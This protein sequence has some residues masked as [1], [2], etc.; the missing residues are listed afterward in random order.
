MRKYTVPVSM[1]V[2]YFLGDH[3]GSTSLSTDAS[4]NKISE[5][6]YKPWGEIR[7]SWT[8]VPSTTPAYSLMDYTFTGQY[9]YMDDPTTG[10]TEGFGLM[11]YNARWY[12]PYLNHFTQPDSIVPDP[13]NP[14]DYDRYSYA[15]NNPLKYTDPTGHDPNPWNPF[16][17]NTLV[18]S[19][20]FSIKAIKGVTFAVDFIAEKHS[21]FTLDPHG[22]TVVRGTFSAGAEGA[23][24]AGVSLRGTNASV[25]TM[26]NDNISTILDQ[27]GVIPAHVAICDGFCFGVSGNV[28]PSNPKWLDNRESVSYFIGGGEGV[29]IGLN[30]SEAKEWV[31]YDPKGNNNLY[32]QIPNHFLD[33]FKEAYQDSKVV[34]NKLL[35]KIKAQ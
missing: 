14:Q 11:F 23:A 29:D 15:R 24:D 12:D 25:E 1:A 16:D 21:I 34:I 13:Y 33:Y 3:L 22:A 27:G 32:G 30:L 5:I 4:G 17:Y 8:S 10:T 26:I 31:L 9:S 35:N 19:I 18:F 6:R 7:S 2:E 28:D 20:S